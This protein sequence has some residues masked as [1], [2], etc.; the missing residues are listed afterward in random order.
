MHNLQPTQSITYM[1]LEKEI[2]IIL[3][4][5]FYSLYYMRFI[6]FPPIIRMQI[7]TISAC[8]QKL[9]NEDAHCFMI[10]HV[11]LASR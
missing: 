1:A 8:I 7:K 10:I 6:L 5:S 4:L 11:S 2:I 9:S 3:K